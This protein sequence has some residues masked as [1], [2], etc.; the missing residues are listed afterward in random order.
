MIT[1]GDRMKQRLVGAA[2]LV[3]AAVVFVPMLLTQDEEPPARIV[4]SEPV[5]E[6][7]AGSGAG[8]SGAGGAV[9]RALEPLPPEPAASAETPVPAPAPAPAPEKQADREKTPAKP[10]APAGEFAVQIGS[11]SRADN[12]HRLRD[13]LKAR[14]YNAFARSSGSVTRVYVGP[15]KTRAAA[16]KMRD[17]LREKMDI[18]G[19][20]VT[21]PG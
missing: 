10:A 15:Q 8:A 4:Q 14:G 13:R 9:T 16:V 3:I 20:V 11:F 21:H 12:A 19:I 6:S 7:D 17:K 2:V 5:A 1:M 18:K